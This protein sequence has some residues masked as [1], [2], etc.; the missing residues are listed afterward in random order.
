MTQLITGQSFDNLVT[1]KFGG[2][3]SMLFVGMD[4]I[5]DDLFITFFHKISGNSL[6]FWTNHVD[7]FRPLFHMRLNS[8]RTQLDKWFKK[9]ENGIYC[10]NLIKTPFLL[11]R[12]WY[13]IDNNSIQ[14]CCPGSGP[15]TAEISPR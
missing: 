12:P 8:P 14:C 7:Y 13:L 10:P 2:G 1:D 5:V 9:A 4:L 6:Q 15:E 3:P 11:F